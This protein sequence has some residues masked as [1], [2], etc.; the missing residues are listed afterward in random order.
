[1]AF[2]AA[3]AARDLKAK[4][5]ENHV[6]KLKDELLV[7]KGRVVALSALL[8]DHQVR[9]ALGAAEKN[10]FHAIAMQKAGV[11]LS[12]YL[13]KIFPSKNQLKS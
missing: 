4:R 8:T 3:I 12:R 11:R 2:A 10:G 6:Q 9:Q 7:E 5:L 1:M 13:L